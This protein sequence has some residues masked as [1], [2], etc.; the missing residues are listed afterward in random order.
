MSV[1][2][3]LMPRVIRRTMSRALPMPPWPTGGSPARSAGSCNGH[4]PI[5]GPRSS[6]AS[7]A[8]ATSAS[9]A[10]DCRPARLRLRCRPSRLPSALDPHFRRVV[11]PSRHSGLAD[12]QEGQDGTGRSRPTMLHVVWWTSRS[13]CGDV[14]VGARSA[15]VSRRWPCGCDLLIKVCHIAKA[16]LQRLMKCDMS[17]P[18]VRR[19]WRAAAPP[20]HLPASARNAP[21][22]SRVR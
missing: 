18:L 6:A 4:W 3:R 12:Q 1:C 16:A 7:A 10:V 9:Q 5:R 20:K 11:G 17:M 13:S 21:V 8:A 15:C 22:S 2:V 19:V 14:C